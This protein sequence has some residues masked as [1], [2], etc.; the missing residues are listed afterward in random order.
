MLDVNVKP[1]AKTEGVH[2]QKGIPDFEQIHLISYMQL[3]DAKA[4]VF[5]AI[6]SGAVAYIAGHYGLGWLQKDGFYGHSL[7]ISLTMLV[8]FASAA[9][10]IAVIVPR[11]SRRRDGI[12]FYHEIVQIGSPAHY[13][14]SLLEM[15]EADIFRKK[16]TY[17]YSLAMICDRKYR[18]LNY[19]LIFGAI[20]YAMFLALL[21]WQ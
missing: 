2:T 4:S 13:L 12:F 5:L 1:R 18:L 19:S 17:C 20:G 21:L 15:S 7:L 8:L 10:D 14:A 9:L 16:M 6:A 3:A 11:K